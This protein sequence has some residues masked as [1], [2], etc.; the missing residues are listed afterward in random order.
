MLQLEIDSR[1]RLAVR[2]VDERS[3][4]ARAL[5]TVRH[6]DVVELA[7]A[8]EVTPGG[9]LRNLVAPVRVTRGRPQYLEARRRRV[10]VDARQRMVGAVGQ[11]ASA[12]DGGAGR[13]GGARNFL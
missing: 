2:D 11:D 4:S 9:K 8:D 10:N 13:G 6:A 12:D 5:L 1:D 7:R 3:R